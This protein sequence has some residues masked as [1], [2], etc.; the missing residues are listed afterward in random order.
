MET[1]IGDLVSHASW[2]PS[3]DACRPL[4]FVI[5]PCRPREGEGLGA[6]ANNLASARQAVELLTS[7]RVA[8]VCPILSHQLM[9]GILPAEDLVRIGVVIAG[10]CDAVVRLGGW[11]GAMGAR[12]SSPHCAAAT[13]PTSTGRRGRPAFMRSPR[14]PAGSQTGLSRSRGTG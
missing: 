1:V 12:R 8:A 3:E 7:F 9:D 4:V 10:R 5:G 2:S 11:R 6:Y 14:R 13:R